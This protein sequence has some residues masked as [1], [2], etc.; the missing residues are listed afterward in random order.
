MAAGIREVTIRRGLDPREFLMLAAGGAGPLHANHIARELGIP[1][2]MVPRD[3]AVFCAAGMLASDLKHDLAVSWRARFTEFG[4][5]EL[6]TRLGALR[7]QC[8][9]VLAEQGVPEERMRFEPGMDIRYLGQYHEVGVPL[10]AEAIDAPDID[11]ILGRFHE[12]HD[13]LYGYATSEMPVECIT[14]RMS[15]RGREDRPE[16]IVLKIGGPPASPVPHGRRPIRLPGEPRRLPAD[17]YR[18]LIPGQ[19]IAGP[20]IVE[21]PNT[22]VLVLKDYELACDALGNYFIWP[23][24]KSG[25]MRARFLSDAGGGRG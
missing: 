12:R 14:I 19:R 17:V 22:T 3:S 16:T 9:A 23:E 2:I 15:A 20:A 8:R 18:A 13:A 25:E 5:E 4:P 7:D 11:G 6:A 21:R 10:P 24:T 1:L